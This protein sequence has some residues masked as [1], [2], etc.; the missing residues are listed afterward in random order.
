MS[1]LVFSATIDQACGAKT[2]NKRAAVVE[3]FRMYVLSN[4]FAFH[5][6]VV[7][8][9]SVFVAQLANENGLATTLQTDGYENVLT[10]S[11]EQKR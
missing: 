2:A 3:D 11:V 6:M 4:I 1:A 10:F 7:C 8:T 9:P 5:L